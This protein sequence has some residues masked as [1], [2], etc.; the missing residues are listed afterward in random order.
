[1]VDTL[2]YYDVMSEIEHFL[3][4]EKQ[5]RYYLDL[6]HRINDSVLVS[7]LNHRLLAVEKKYDLQQEELKNAQLLA[8]LRGSWLVIAFIVIAALLLGLLLLR[9]RNRLRIKE[10]EQGVLKADL[11]QSLLS[12]RQVQGQLN[13]YEQELQAS[14]VA[15]REQMVAQTLLAQERERLSSRIA[16]LEG[17]KQQSDELRTIINHQIESIHQLMTWSYQFEGD[18]F[19]NKFCEMMSLPVNSTDDGSYWVNLHTL[20]NDLHDNVL[21]RAQERAGGTLSN[22]EMNL[23]ALYCCGFSRTVIMV[24]MGYKSI[25]TVYNK[26]AQIARKLQV[27]NLDHYIKTM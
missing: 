8:R 11:Q 27:D 13:S 20:V 7:G 25:G 1:M 24:C 16:A 19:A 5:S 18:K 22:S 4:N 12:L 6:Y 17:K 2:V 3:H 15:L 21:V 26:I 23:L 9:Y 10:Q 14:E